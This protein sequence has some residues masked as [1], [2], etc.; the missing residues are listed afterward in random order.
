MIHIILHFSMIAF[1]ASV[2]GKPDRNQNTNQART[3][4]TRKSQ[5]HLYCG[6]ICEI[7]QTLFLSN[8]MSSCLTAIITRSAA[9]TATSTRNLVTTSAL[10]ARHRQIGRIKKV[11]KRVIHI[12]TLSPPTIRSHYGLVVFVFIVQ[13]PEC[14]DM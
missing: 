1:Y 13:N 9:L 6:N 4:G 5:I 3:R 11:P 14:R 7:H 10:V 12:H 2:R 8:K